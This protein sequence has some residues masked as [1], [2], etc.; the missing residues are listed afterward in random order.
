MDSETL[1]DRVKLKFAS[2]KAGGPEIDLVKRAG[3]AAYADAAFSAVETLPDEA[4]VLLAVSLRDKFRLL[5][6]QPAVPR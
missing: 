4:L 3:D 6:A 5:A 1:N 2:R